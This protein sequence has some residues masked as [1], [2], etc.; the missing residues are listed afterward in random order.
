MDMDAFNEDF[1]V[2]SKGKAKSYEI[3]YKSLSQAAIE[4]L[5]QEDV[6]HI[7]GIFGVDVSTVLFDSRSNGC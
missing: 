4:A 6:D 3:S 5:M 1:K 2:S 7:S